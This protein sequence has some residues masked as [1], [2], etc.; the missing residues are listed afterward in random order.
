MHRSAVT[1]PQGERLNNANS[2]ISEI[3]LIL[4]LEFYMPFL[5]GQKMRDGMDGGVFVKVIMLCRAPE[6]EPCN[7]TSKEHTTEEIF[8]NV[9]DTDL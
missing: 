5:L 1:N 3:L 7:S 9:R 2:N 8:A 6:W 4:T